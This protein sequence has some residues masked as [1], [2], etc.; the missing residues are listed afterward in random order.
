MSLPSAS[1]KFDLGSH[2]GQIDPAK[3]VPADNDTIRG[4]Q[5]LEDSLGFRWR[6]EVL[7]NMYA[8]GTADSFEKHFRSGRYPKGSKWA[9]LLQPIRQGSRGVRVPDAG[10]EGAFKIMS[11]TLKYAHP[12]D[13]ES[14]APRS[15]RKCCVNGVKVE[16]INSSLHPPATSHCFTFTIPRH[17]TLATVV[18][19]RLESTLSAP[20]GPPAESFLSTFDG[21]SSFIPSAGTRDNVRNLTTATELTFHGVTLT[22]WQHAGKSFTRQLKAIREQLRQGDARSDGVVAGPVVPELP[23]SRGGKSKKQKHGKFGWAVG[24][25]DTEMSDVAESEF[26]SPFHGRFRDE[27]PTPKVFEEAGDV[28]WMPYALTVISRHPI[29]DTML[30][31]LRC[32]VS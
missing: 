19:D 24:Q 17:D 4:V 30:D 20:S 23:T 12:R 6:P 3:W 11:K 18:R 2:K 25:T 29:Y 9:Q 28:F 27:P 1:R 13:G 14:R 7:G 22:V 5:P 31:Y 26:D 8:G 15:L 21:Q 10:P 32:S 16:V